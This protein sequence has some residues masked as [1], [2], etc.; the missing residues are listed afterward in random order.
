MPVKLV[1]LKL[2]YTRDCTEIGS[3]RFAGEPSTNKVVQGFSQISTN[4]SPSSKSFDPYSPKQGN[5]NYAFLHQTQVL[6]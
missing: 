5:M 6:N 1:N 3:L 2:N 4:F